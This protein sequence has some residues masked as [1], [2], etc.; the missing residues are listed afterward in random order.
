MESPSPVPCLNELSLQKRSNTSV[1]FSFG[2]PQPVSLTL[3]LI[4]SSLRSFSSAMV[5][6]PFS[7]HFFALVVRLAS[8]CSR[9]SRSVSIIRRLTF[10]ATRISTS[11]DLLLAS[12]IFA[13]VFTSATTSCSPMLNFSLPASIFDTS[14]T[15]SMSFSSILLLVMMRSAYCL[16]SSADISIWSLAKSCEKP[17]TALSGV[18]IS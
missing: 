2:M 13:A 11:A 4:M 15:S 9:R 17:S 5:I 6:V 16:R 10:V 1:A 3:M 14:S 7:V 18:R 12:A 8:T